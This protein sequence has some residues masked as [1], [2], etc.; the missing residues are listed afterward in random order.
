[1]YGLFREERQKE[2]RRAI[3]AIVFGGEGRMEEFAVAR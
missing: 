2:A 1:M 3:R